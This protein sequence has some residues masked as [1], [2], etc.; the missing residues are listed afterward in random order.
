[1]KRLI[2]CFVSVLACLSCQTT[3]PKDWNPEVL[4]PYVV[5]F[6][7]PV[8]DG[9][10]L[11]CI[12]DEIRRQIRCTQFIMPPL[13]ISPDTTN[14]MQ[15]NSND[16]DYRYVPKIMHDNWDVFLCTKPEC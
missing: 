14:E 8:E 6:E 1:M 7:L 13:R 11:A 15:F 2:M 3:G 5:V 4:P 10:M 12:V 16:I 9:D